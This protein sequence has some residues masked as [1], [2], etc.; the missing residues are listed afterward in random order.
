M[1]TKKVYY[2]SDIIKK[3]GVRRPGKT[4]KDREEGAPP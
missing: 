2:Y 1:A 4:A 3:F